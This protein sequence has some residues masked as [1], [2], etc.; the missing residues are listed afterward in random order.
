MTERARLFVAVALDDA[1]RSACADVAERLRAK[2]FP[3]RFVP[4]ENYHLTVAF[5]GGVDGER[6]TEIGGALES[7]APRVAPFAVPLDAVGAFPNGK[8]PRVAWVGPAIPVPAYGTLCGVVRSQLTAMGFSFDPHADPHVTLARSG[9][10]RALPA[11][12]PPRGAAVTVDAL[13]LYESF[14]R[15][16]GARYEPRA[17]VPLG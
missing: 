4:R 10:E 11:V 16:E 9:G 3:G 13:V 15:A 5:L 12:A 2:G 17:R 14:T 7:L 8:R 6:M 1:A